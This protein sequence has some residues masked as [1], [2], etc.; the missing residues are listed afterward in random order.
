MEPDRRAFPLW[1]R[2]VLNAVLCAPFA[3]LHRRSR[4][5]R[6]ARAASSNG[7]GPAKRAVR[8]CGSRPRR[9]MAVLSARPTRSQI[10]AMRIGA[11][12]L[13]YQPACAPGSGPATQAPVS[14]ITATG[15]PRKASNAPCGWPAGTAASA[16]SVIPANMQRHVERPTPAST[17]Q[18]HERPAAVRA[19]LF[20]VTQVQRLDGG[21]AKK[22]SASAKCEIAQRGYMLCRQHHTSATMPGPSASR[23]SRSPTG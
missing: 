8:Y 22:P 13:D 16:S 2:I 15:R 21:Q 19:V 23:I 17:K 1:S 6:H 9:R 3:V 12:C 20:E 10:P 5:C 11:D 4:N 18:R 14:G 7:G